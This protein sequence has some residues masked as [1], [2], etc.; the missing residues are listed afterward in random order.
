MNP[1]KDTQRISNGW[2]TRRT[3]EAQFNTTSRQH[4]SDG[5]KELPL[6]C[7]PLSQRAKVAVAWR[8]EF[9]PLSISQVMSSVSPLSSCVSIKTVMDPPLILTEGDSSSGHS[10]K[11]VKRPDSSLP[12]CVS[13]K[14]DQSM[15][16]PLVFKDAEPSPG[17]S[18]LQMGGNRKDEK[19]VTDPGCETSYAGTD[20]QEKCKLNL[21]K[22]FQ[23]MSEP[24]EKLS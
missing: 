7:V 6:K 13:M 22:K 20:V 15:D 17:H 4:K 14:S 18:V 24:P 1:E 16:H 21:I 2:A 23:H 12:S 10:V 8:Q 19:I 11:Q 5:Q 3:H 9:F